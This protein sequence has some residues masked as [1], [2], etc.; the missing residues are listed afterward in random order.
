MVSKTG[1]ERQREYYANNQGPTGTR[2]P[3]ATWDFFNTRTRPIQQAKVFSKTCKKYSMYLT[4]W[5]ITPILMM[6]KS[7]VNTPTQIVTPKDILYFVIPGH[8]TK[9]DQMFR[10]KIFPGYF[11]VLGRQAGTC[12]LFCECFDPK[13]VHLGA[14]IFKNPL[15]SF[16]D[17]ISHIMVA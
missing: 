7:I 5:L 10:K 14:P 15:L 6:N 13:N 16:W 12:V 1:D 9:N 8:L 4:T 11:F 3:P 17:K 2:Y